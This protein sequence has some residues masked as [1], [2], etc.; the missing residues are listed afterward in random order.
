M[1]AEVEALIGFTLDEKEILR[2]LFELI[3]Y[4]QYAALRVEE[5]CDFLRYRQFHNFTVPECQEKTDVMELFTTL[6][7][8]LVS[9]LKQYGLYK[10]GRLDY[11][12]DSFKMG[13]ILIRQRK[14]YYD[15]LRKEN[16]C[17]S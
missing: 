8:I 7:R 6:G 9:D 3:E 4:E 13:H 11:L 12:F 5:H 14:S 2:K 16:A 10:N 15:I 17:L 1:C